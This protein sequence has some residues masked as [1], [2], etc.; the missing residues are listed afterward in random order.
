VKYASGTFYKP[1]TVMHVSRG[2]SG[3]IPWRWNCL[4]EV[5]KLTLVPAAKPTE[6]DALRR[7]ETS[8]A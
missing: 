5:T 1:P 4:P 8:A 6:P 3:E 2:V 7:M